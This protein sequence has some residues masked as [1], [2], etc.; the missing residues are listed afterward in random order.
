MVFLRVSGVS[1]GGSL[2][3]LPPRLVAQQETHR[4]MAKLHRWRHLH[5]LVLLDEGH[6]GRSHF[7]AGSRMVLGILHPQRPPLH[8]RR[9]LDV[10]VHKRTVGEPVEPPGHLQTRPPDIW[11]VPDAHVL[12]RPHRRM[13][14]RRRPRQS[15]HPGSPR[16]PRHRP[17]QLRL[18]CPD[19]LAALLP[20]RQQ[21]P[22]RHG[23]NVQILVINSVG[24]KSFINEK[25]N[26][27]L[28]RSFIDAPM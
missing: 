19:H 15:H 2:Y 9:L 28:P 13:D 24:V 18:Q 5:G 21:V 6:P 22:R 25:A 27:F 16:H 10:H 4:R 14:R 8:L 1:R 26:H 7:Y 17:A 3:P 12:P 23:V 20:P 11:D